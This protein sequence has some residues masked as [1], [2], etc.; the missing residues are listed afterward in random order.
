[1][2]VENTA[3]AVL[4]LSQ[5]FIRPW[6]S[7]SKNPITAVWLHPLPIFTHWETVTHIAYK[8]EERQTENYSDMNK[9]HGSRLAPHCSK[10]RNIWGL[11]FHGSAD[12]CC[13]IQPCFPWPKLLLQPGL[14]AS[15]LTSSGSAAHCTP[16]RK[17]CH[18][19]VTFQLK[20]FSIK[21]Q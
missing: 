6:I 21:K 11:V 10:E 9:K 20:L 8:I 4:Q 1:M 3:L 12:G 14:A 19:F 2:R 16:S 17:L 7:F 5:N 18:V 15:T 13:N